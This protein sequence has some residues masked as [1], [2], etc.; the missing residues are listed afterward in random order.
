MIYS[1]SIRR[2]AAFGALLFGLSLAGLSHGVMAPEQEGTKA[3]AINMLDA[4]VNARD[5]WQRSLDAQPQASANGTAA[6][7]SANST[8]SIAAQQMRDNPGLSVRLSGLTGAPN[9]VSHTMGTLTQAAPGKSSESIVREY[10]RGSGGTLMGLSAGDVDDLR[11]LGD[12]NG[13]QSGLRM[14]RVEQQIDG[15]PVFQS[16]SRFLIDQSGRLVKYVGVMVPRA[17]ALVPTSSKNLTAAAASSRLFASIGRQIPESSFSV[18]GSGDGGRTELTASDEFIAGPVVAREVLFPLAPGVLVKAWSLIA[19]TSGKSDWYSIVDATTGD[20]LWRKNI[21]D[22]ASAHEARFRVYVQ[23]DR[24]T[25]ADSPAPQSPTT[26]TPGSGFQA[27]AIAPTVVNMSAVQDIVASPNGWIN[28]CP[29]GGCTASETQ[30]L[31]NNVIACVD[32]VQGNVAGGAN[33][34]DTAAAGVLDGNG[35]PT[36]NPDTNSRNRD[37]LGTTPRDFETN[38]LPAPQG[39]NPEAGQTATG[40]GTSGTAAIDQFR[41]GVVTHLFYLTNW[42]HDQTFQ[43]G[44]DEAAGNF[45]QTNFSASGAGNDPVLAEAVDGSGTNNANFSTPPDGTSGR[46]QMYRFTGPIIDRDGSLDAEIVLHELTHGLSNRLVG[47]AAGLNWDH[48]RSMGEGWSDFYAL[49]LLNNTNADDPNGS[50]ASGAY[51][52][53]KLSAGFTDNYLYGIR[54]FPYSTNIAVNPLT[55]ADVDDVTNDM[56]GGITPTPITFNLNGGMEVHNAGE[57]WANT[58][59]GMRAKI[60]ADPAG[61]N[62]NVPA[63]NVAS[64]KLVT[65]ALK[66]TPINPTFVDARNALFDADCAVSACGNE[67][68]IWTAF[69]YRG[70]GYRADSPYGIAGRYVS[71]HTGFHESF[72]KPYLDVKNEVTDVTI[73]DSATNNNGAIDP[74]ESFFMTVKLFNPWRAAAKS[75][76]GITATLT[77]A[78]PG[79]TIY[80]GT[81]TYGT[82]AAQG[83]V[84]GGQFKIGVSTS[85][86]AGAP[87]DF[88]LTTTSSLG[89]TATTFRVRVGTRAGTDPVVTYSKAESPALTIANSRPRGVF[90]GISITDDFEIAD[91]N[92]RV[93][94]ITHPAVG[95]LT[96]M[97]RSPTGIGTDLIS[98]VDGLNDYGGASIVNMVIDDDVAAIAA[99][100]MVQAVSTAAPYTKSWLSVYNSPWAALVDPTVPADAVLNLSRYD[101]TSTKGTWNALVADVFSAAAGGE[102][103]NGNGTFGGWSLLVTPVHF[104][105]SA[106]T[107]AAVVTAT[108]TVAGTFRVGGTVTYTV[109]L[110]NTGSGNQADNAGNEFTDV[111]PAGLTLVSATATSGTAATSGNTATWNGSLA[112]L[113]GSV[114]ITI[115]A[116]VNAGTQGTTIS[117]QGTVSYDADGNGTNES[118][119]LT[120][121]P[122]V[123]GA[124][125]PTVFAVAFASVTASKTVSGGPHAIG[126]TVTYTVVLNNSGNA[127]TLNNAG[128]EF[129]DILPSGLTLVSASATGGT[130]VATVGTNTVTWDGSIPATGSVTITITATINASASGTISNQGTLL[131][132]TDLNGSNETTVLTDDPTVAGAANPTVFSL[133]FATVTATKTVSV[134]PHPIGSAVTYTI[135]LTNSGNTATTDNAGNELTDV[136]PIGLTLTGATASAGTAVATIATRTVTWNGGIPAG[137]AVTITINALVNAIAASSIVSNQATYAYDADLNGSNESTGLT[138]D[139]TVAGPAN[140]TTFAADA[141]PPIPAASSEALWLIGLMLMAMGALRLRS[142]RR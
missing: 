17:R 20:V 29:A 97:L 85:M 64:L 26:A 5:A 78:T 111:L 23:A 95:D 13:G 91:V 71:S 12:S 52:T 2:A 46:M 129:T 37:F 130:A 27:A 76:T 88:T 8:V 61:A 69:A 125:N 60:I 55:W 116:T 134:G 53:Y 3:E 82:I 107:P 10:L 123:A 83:S 121:D 89:T 34:C 14:L 114:T 141:L 19:F 94:S 98:L 66:M 40:N 77:T 87:I 100:D 28:D 65:N 99:N 136:L 113:G 41:R 22:Y 102:P 138:D 140:A 54:R 92:F 1:D 106:V 16:E 25:P 32:Q 119:V 109:T 33:L 74:G 63:G 115:T 50:Y 75:A 59:W 90:S 86:V 110:T 127:A 137:G 93:N 58:L 43:L 62:G 30:T 7:A 42:Y 139:P 135:I 101:G 57:L 80:T 4:R 56:S 24:K 11:V 124:A 15:I 133:N 120:D 51:A 6:R 81:A 131:V 36:G 108:K 39:G 103:T 84:T 18:S 38:F 126:S 21:R 47:N 48:A 117:N 104:N 112:P 68:S 132:D 142:K 73:L 72:A 35:R 9:S 96:V 118:T 45:Q 128:S 49:S 79:V 31:G 122:A 70:F 44:F 67:D 105:V